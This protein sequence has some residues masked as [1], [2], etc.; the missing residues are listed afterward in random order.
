MCHSGI[1][2][3]KFCGVLRNLSA[4]VLLVFVVSL[5]VF[6]FVLLFV[7]IGVIHFF[8]NYRAADD[9]NDWCYHIEAFDK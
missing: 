7:L 9:E 2:A 6:P 1:V 8:K 5:V 4:F 3:I